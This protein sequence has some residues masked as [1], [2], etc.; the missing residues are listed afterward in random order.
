MK[1]FTTLTRVGLVLVS[2]TS[3]FYGKSALSQTPKRG[4]KTLDVVR[5]YGADSTGTTYATAKIQKAISDCK[6]GDT[7][8]IPDGTYL[9]NSGLNLK[10][11]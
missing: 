1:K 10:S 6:P 11:G 8:L 5:D 4:S 2:L 9:M 3:L 7:L